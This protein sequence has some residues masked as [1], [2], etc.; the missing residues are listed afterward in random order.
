MIGSGTMAMSTQELDIKLVTVSPHRWAKLPIMT[1]LLEGAA[2]ELI[3]VAVTG[4]PQKPQ[5]TARPLR[6]LEKAI[7]T[8]VIPD[9]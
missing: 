9:D 7:N 4:T 5:A 6:G 3:E 2:R 1:E 8:L